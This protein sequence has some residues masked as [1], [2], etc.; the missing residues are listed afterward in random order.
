MQAFRELNWAYRDYLR[1][2]PDTRALAEV[3]YP[4]DILAAAL[5]DEAAYRPPLGR[6]RLVMHS[7][8][9]VGCGSVHT[10]ATGDAEIKRVFLTEQAR[11]SGLGW[12]L[13]NQLLKD[14]RDLG[15]ARVVMDTGIQ[16]KAAQRFYDRMGFR[17]RGP[18]QEVPDSMRGQLV[19]FEMDLAP[20]TAKKP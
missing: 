7:G 20:S 15:H 4:D 19:F 1:D 16:L 9:A 10:L 17:R 6:M 2:D 8:R 13:M 18:Y 11:G 14:A 3:F 5:A 12:G